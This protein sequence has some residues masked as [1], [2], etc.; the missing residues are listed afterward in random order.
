M[1]NTLTGGGGLECGGG[2]DVLC[3]CRVEDRLQCAISAF[4]ATP[5]FFTVA[6]D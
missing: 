6:L 3:G 4:I 5:P 2:V 1:C